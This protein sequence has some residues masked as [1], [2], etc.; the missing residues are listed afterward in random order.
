[1]NQALQVAKREISAFFSSLVALLFILAFLFTNLFIFFW[2]EAFFARNIADIRPL[3]EWM[4]LLLI[5]LVSALTMRMWSEERKSG[6]IEFLLTLPMSNFQLVLGKFLSCMALI[7]LA[8]LLTLPI[9][10]TVSFFGNIDWGPVFAAYIATLFLGAAYTSIGL[11]ISSRNENQIVSLILTVAICFVFYMIGSDALTPLVGNSGSEI[12]KLVGTGSRFESIARGV[13]DFR[14][15]Y[16]YL[17]IIGIFLCLNVFTLEK[18]RWADN[19]GVKG[20]RHKTWRLL[21]VLCIANFALA[22]FWLTP[23]SSTRVDFTENNIYSI[24]DATE[25]YI[26]QLQEPLLIRGYFSEKTHPLLAPLVPQVRDLILEYQAVS[27]GKVRAEFVDPKFN[28]DLEEEAGKKYG[29]KPV[30]FQISGKYEASLVN[31]YFDILIQYG[32]KYEVLNFQDLIEVQLKGEGELN[33]ELR[34]PEYDITRSIKKVLYGFQTREHLFA[35][36]K[37]PVTFVGYISE[38]QKLPEQLQNY[39]QE[40]SKLLN[41]LT[42]SSDGKFKVSFQDPADSGIQEQIEVDY[43]FRPMAANLFSD[44]TFYFYTLLKAQDKT[45]LVPLPEDLSAESAERSIDAA[46]KRFSTG[47]LKTVALVTPKAPPPNPYMGGAGGKQ[48]RMLEEKL[49]ENFTVESTDLSSGTVPDSADLLLLAAPDSLGEKELFAV[50]Q[51]LMKGGTVVAA[52]SPFSI[53][54]TQQQISATDH[55]SGLSEWLSH[56]GL[57][58]EKQ[59][60]LD[61]QNENYPVPVQRNLGGFSVQEIKMVPYPFF[62]DIRGDG[63][64]QDTILTS[65]IPQVTLNW[66]S[67]IT[68]AKS[69]EKKNIKITKLLES[70]DASWLSDSKKIIPDYQLYPS[71]GFPP[72]DMKPSTLGVVAE[73]EFSSYF[74]GKENPLLKQPAEEEKDEGEPAE[75]KEPEQVISG[76]I[77]KSSDSARII[78]FASNEFVADQTLQ[79]SAS[80]GGNR[81][82]NSLQLI[83]NSI[84]WS[85]EDRGLLSIRS[86][87]HFSRTLAPMTKSQQLFWEGLNYFLTLLGVICLFLLYRWLRNNK[88]ARLQNILAHQHGV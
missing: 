9:P 2:V 87:G 52:T 23:L 37:E 43:G 12:L 17:S 36:L 86:R 70:S 48:F 66:S 82:L 53:S 63:L 30:P 46:L 19:S 10:I 60:V 3:F 45:V 75:K 22:N 62:V 39:K 51:F 31:S 85:L 29:I 55:T 16:Y 61:T 1:M 11:F 20:S 18:L 83:E 35:S 79:I 58:I 56:N 65:G 34:N 84:D 74:A 7:A 72:S 69:Q 38:D 71:S 21:T 54:R 27:D 49:S 24:S 81:F 64:N 50:D 78:L 40:L 5:F 57:S 47:F 77:E 26:S 42:E 8:L 28:A 14:D 44:Q 15:L 59:L 88:T 76:I 41:S 68:I 13:I 73:G 25:S 33:V 6:T 4:P 67:P 80:V 32:D